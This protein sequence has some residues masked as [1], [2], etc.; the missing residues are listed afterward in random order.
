MSKFYYFL[1]R[2]YFYTFDTGEEIAE[3]IG[4]IDLEDAEEINAI[5]N[6]STISLDL[7][8]LNQLIGTKRRIN[9]ASINEKQK[10]QRIFTLISKLAPD[11][12]NKPPSFNEATN[13]FNSAAYAIKLGRK[14]GSKLE[15][16]ANQCLFDITK[17]I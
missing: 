9:F 12:K 14:S 13:F 8:P 2:L 1:R 4:K 16:A 5:I 6:Q 7:S 15:E 17:V 10:V 3:G 11:I